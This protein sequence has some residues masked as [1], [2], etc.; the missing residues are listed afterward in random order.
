M[1]EPQTHE[2]CRYV[3]R[4]GDRCQHFVDANGLCFWHNPHADKKNVNIKGHLEQMARQG[5]SLEGF[6][7]AH[8]DLSGV[9]LVR[10]G[11][12]EPTNLADADLYRANLKHAHFFNVDISGGSL[13]K[14]DLTGANFNLANLSG[15]NL[16]GTK[17]NQTKLENVTWGEYLLQEKQAREHK[18]KGDKRNTLRLFKEAEEIYRHLQAACEGMG[19]YDNAGVFLQRGM[20]VRRFQYPLIS[21]RRLVSKLVDLSCGYGEDPV[22]VIIFSLFIIFSFGF[23]FFLFGIKGPEH[24]IVYN[25]QLAI[26]DNLVLLL[27]ALYFS[28]VTFTTLGY[29]DISPVGITRFFATFEAFV[30]SFSLALFVV[31]FVK[32]MTR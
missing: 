19:L 8:A 15:T 14:A 13:M 27:E 3:F 16:L 29:G 32:K 22:R 4:N 26:S 17:F 24:P 6:C 10:S 25:P 12:H 1:T 31:V 21:G 23:I 30:G 9:N 5:K 7:L 18:S 28:V 2:T 20:T 11:T